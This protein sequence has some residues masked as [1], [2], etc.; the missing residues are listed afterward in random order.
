MQ[1]ALEFLREH[2]EIAFATSEGNLPRLR[3]FQIKYKPQGKHIKKANN[4][5]NVCLND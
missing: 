2:N 4:Y 3:I 1:R 5:L